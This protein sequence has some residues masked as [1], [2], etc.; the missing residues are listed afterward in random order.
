MTLLHERDVSIAV[1]PDNVPGDIRALDTLVRPDYMDCVTVTTGRATD[2]SPE[3]WL[4]ATLEDTRGGRSAPSF[5]RLLGLRLAPRPSP[6]HVQGWKIAAGGD[7]WIRMETSSWYMTA[8]A[9]LRLARRG[10]VSL[11]LFIRF[12]RRIAA[13]VWPPV[14]VLHRRVVPSM[15]RQAARAARIANA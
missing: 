15:L 3:D 10:E 13:I 14:G 12:D 8:H 9:V 7:D 2:A 6:G 4:R 5:W 1:G 11:A